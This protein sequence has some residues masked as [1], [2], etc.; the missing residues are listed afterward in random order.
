MSEKILIAYRGE[1]AFRIIRSM[2]MGVA[3]VA[4]Y[5]DADCW[6]MGC[7]RHKRPSRRLSE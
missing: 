6:R 5:S 4:V 2:R 3:T 1:I 7:V